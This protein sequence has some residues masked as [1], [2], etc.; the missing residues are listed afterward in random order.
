[1]KTMKLNFKH[2]LL[3]FILFIFSQIIVKAQQ[4]TDYTGQVFPINNALNVAIDNLPVHPNSE[5]F[6]KSIGENKSLHPDF[7]SYWD[8]DGTIMPMGIPYNVVSNQPLSPIEFVWWPEESDL[9]PWP[10]PEN[11]YIEGVT[12]WR[13]YSEGDRHMLI[14]DSGNQMLYESGN[15]YGKNNGSE[16]EAGCGA[17]FDLKTNNLRP[18]T[19]TSADAAGLPIF[20]LL[21]RYDE[22]ERALKGDGMFHHA[23]RFTVSKSQRAYLWPARHYASSSTD[24]NL[25]PMGLR[26]RLKK[27]VDISSYPPK[28]QV[29]LRSMKKYGIIVSDNGGDWFFQ[30][31]HDDRWNDEEINTLKRIKGSDFEAVDISE[32]FGMEGF[33]P[34]SAEVPFVYTSNNS[35]NGRQKELILYQNYPNP[36]KNS[37]I[38]SFYLPNK[39]FVILKIYDILGNEVKTLAEGKLSEGLHNY[40]WDGKNSSGIKVND[41][42]YILILQTEGSSRKIRKILFS[43]K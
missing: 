15:V 23:I 41:G 14:I 17:V 4:M 8:N 32:W 33:N 18:E 31:T 28:I 7:G 1:M 3:C 21:I 40:E 11:P 25:S 42:M 20:P 9:G 39:T 43:D 12:D 19:W 10:I 36:F 27:E 2:I 16:W 24:K 35:Q 13:E 26:F 30:G 29:I 22:V 5:N 38:I 34:N 6:I 37:T